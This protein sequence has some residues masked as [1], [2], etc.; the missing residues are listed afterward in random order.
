[1]SLDISNPRDLSY[2][3]L[4]VALMF[5]QEKLSTKIITSPCED[6]RSE[7]I[8]EAYIFLYFSKIFYICLVDGGGNSGKVNLLN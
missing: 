7:Q 2:L 1:M 5:L 8:R 3:K 4:N 6:R